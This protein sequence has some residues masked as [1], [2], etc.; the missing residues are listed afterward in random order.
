ME[1]A[2]NLCLYS[3]L[4]SSQL[5]RVG[6]RLADLF[7]ALTD[8]RGAILRNAAAGDRTLADSRVG[9]VY[10]TERGGQAFF[11]THPEGGVTLVYR[12]SGSG[13]WLDNGLGLSGW[14]MAAEYQCLGAR[15]R[16]QYATGQQLQ[17][18]ELACRWAERYRWREITVTGHSKG[19]NKAQFITLCADFVEKCYSF[20]GQGFSP[21]AL[22]ELAQN[23]QFAR[24]QKRLW[25]IAADNDFVNV[26]GES[27]VPETQRLFL[28]TQAEE[29]AAFHAMESLLDERGH[30][31]PVG[32][33]GLLSEA[34]E[35]VSR[36]VMALPPALRQYAT[37]GLIAAVEG[38]KDVKEAAAHLKSMIWN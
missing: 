36:R 13:E 5:P 16:L 32:T 18:L 24:R 19:G 2:A 34:A 30:L 38:G 22:S 7:D 27:A 4:W 33:Q 20:D 10:Y 8:P 31:R 26:L 25:S 37:T 28:Q 3:Y 12:G 6:D 21:E 23:E 17:A 1:R 9:G 15:R 14:P 11:V 29:L 35:A